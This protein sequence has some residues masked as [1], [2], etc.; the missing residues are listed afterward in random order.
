MIVCSHQFF[1]FIQE[2]EIYMKKFIPLIASLLIL[3][4]CGGKGSNADASS[5][6]AG[7][8]SSAAEPSSAKEEVKLT[9]L[10][11]GEIYI[12]LN[13][14]S[15]P[16]GLSV[17]IGDQTL[18]SSGKVKMTQDFN[19]EIEGVF[20]NSVNVYH[21]IDT[22]S[23]R[24]VGASNG[25]DAEVALERIGQYLSNF[26]SKQYEYRVYFCLSDKDKG[27]SKDLAGV[28]EIL[29]AYTGQK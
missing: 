20:T 13:F 21:I 1:V 16:T 25:L 22:G 18:T 26:A 15:A 17:K 8:E 5:Q 7:G 19:Y 23:A 9:F 10:E 28:D 29:T 2:K 3:A 14:E 27:W 4:S 12:D 11:P 6:P 24:S